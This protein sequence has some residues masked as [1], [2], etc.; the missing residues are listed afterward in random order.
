MSGCIFNNQQLNHS[1]LSAEVESTAFVRLVVILTGNS[2][3]ATES[4]ICNLNSTYPTGNYDIIVNK[5]QR[6]TDV[7][8]SV[9]TGQ[10]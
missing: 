7:I 4:T 10:I 5:G 9:I 8:L 3:A 1:F 2:M 6:K